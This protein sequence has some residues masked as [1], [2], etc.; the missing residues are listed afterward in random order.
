LETRC[1]SPGRAASDFANIYEDSFATDD[2]AT[3]L[4]PLLFVEVMP[5]L[6]ALLELANCLLWA[7]KRDITSEIPQTMPTMHP[8]IFFT[9]LASTRMVH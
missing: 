3:E 6:L 5:E 8:C 2:G 1:I 7:L 9:Q 4:V